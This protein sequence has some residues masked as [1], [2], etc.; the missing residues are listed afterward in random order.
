MSLVQ[1]LKDNGL[2]TNLCKFDYIRQLGEGGNSYVYLFQYNETKYAIKLLKKTIENQKEKLNRFKDEYFCTI[3]I[4][5]P[6]LARMY[7]YDEVEIEEEIYSIIIMKLYDKSLKEIK[8]NDSG[9]INNTKLATHVFNSLIEAL[10][11]LHNNGVIHRDIK[12]ENIL[13]DEN[14]HL[15]VLSDFGIAHF[16][17]ETFPKQSNETT[18]AAR[19]ANRFFSAPEQQTGDAREVSYS[20]DIFSVGQVIYWILTGSTLQGH[21]D[22]RRVIKEKNTSQEADQDNQITFLIQFL[23]KALKQSPEERFQ[24]IEE[25]EQFKK[26]F[27]NK[28]KKH[29][30]DYSQYMYDF[31]EIFRSSFASLLNVNDDACSSTTDEKIIFNFMT[32]LQ[33]NLAENKYWI[34]LEGGGDLYLENLENINP[35]NKKEWLLNYYELDISKLII[36]RNFSK[37]YKNFAVLLLNANKPFELHNMKGELLPNKNLSDNQKIKDTARFSIENNYYINSENEIESGYYFDINGDS[38]K[39]NF[40][41]FPTRVRNLKQSAILIVLNGHASSRR[42]DREPAKKLLN[43]IITH[44]GL[45]YEDLNNYLEQTDSEHSPDFTYLD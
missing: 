20:S 15:F 32:K 45:L 12:P 19:L 28:N 39:V 30:P 3:Q 22:I 9:R 18:K 37:L 5:H 6:N 21:E 26:D 36:Y 35:N 8:N 33:Q 43:S 24:T 2:E 34:V 1:Y 11:H 14:N 7:H 31:D 16:D 4:P 38:I 29:T 10:K 41:N 40:E 27:N 17:S 44:Q 23:I 13:Y 42:S 25:I